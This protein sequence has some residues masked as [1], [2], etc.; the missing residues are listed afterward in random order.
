MKR[1][2]GIIFLIPCFLVAQKPT[3]NSISPRNLEVGDTITISGSNLGNASTRVFF[4]TSEATSVSGSANLLQAVVPAGVT[5]GHVT[6]LNTSNNLIGQS[7]ELFY[8][9]F[10][11][12]TSPT[13]GTESIVATGAQDAYD[14][15]LC[16]LNADNLNDVV[17]AHQDV[18][19][20]REVSYFIN[21]ST[22]STTNFGSAIAFD[23][24]SHE[25]GFVSVSCGDL[26]NDGTSEIVF[27][28]VNAENPF[29][30]YVYQGLSDTTPEA[31]LIIPQSGGVN[32]TPLVVK[33]SDIDNDG[34]KDIV[35]GVSSDD[36]D[37]VYIFRNQGSLTFSS[38][39]EI[40][41]SG[42]PNTGAFD[43][44]DLNNDL[45]PDIVILPFNVSN[46][47]IYVLRNNSLVNNFSFIEQAIISNSDQR[48]NLVL[49]DFNNDGLADIA[50]TS[51]RTVGSTS[52]DER[53]SIF[54]NTSDGQSD[55]SIT[56]SLVASLIIPSN[57]PW[58]L[59]AGDLNG[60]GLL[61][62]AIAC[63]GN[64]V[65]TLENTTTTNISFASA[66]LQDAASNTRNIAIGDLNGD[67]KPDI[68]YTNNVSLNTNGDLGVQMNTTC[69]DPTITPETFSFCTGDDFVLTATNSVNATYTWTIQSGTG[70][71]TPNTPNNNQATINLTS[72]SDATIRVQ[73]TQESC[74]VF[75]DYVV[76]FEPGS[77]TSTPTIQV[78]DTNGG[79]ICEGDQVTLSTST[80]FD[81]YLWMLPDGSTSSSSS[82]SL[83][84]ITAANA[85]EYSLIVRNTGNCS[86]VEVSQSITVDA[87]PIP[88]IFNNDDDVF[89]NDGLNDPTLEIQPITGMTYQWRRDG[90]DIT[91]SGTSLTVDQSGDYSIVIT[92]GNNCTQE[93]SPYTITAVSEPVSSINAV[94]E[95]CINVPTTFTATSTGQSGFTLEY[96][97]EVDGT[98]VS[99]TTPTELTTSFS[100]TGNHT[101]T[102]TTSYDATEVS[103]CS[104]QTVF[105][106]TVSPEPVVTFDQ[107]DGTQKCQAETL[108]IDVTTSNVSSYTWSVRNATNSPND[109]L[110]STGSSVV[111]SIDLST[112]ADVDSVYAIVEIV[113]NIGCQVKDSIKIRNFPSTIDISSPDFTTVLTDNNALLEEAIS[114]NLTAENSTN[115][116]WGPEA[117]ADRFSDVDATSTTFF[118]QNPTTVVTLT[119]TDNDGCLSATQITIQL[120]NLRPKKTFSPNGDGIND[121][122]E[123]LNIGDQGEANQCKV[124]I[125]DARGRN[126]LVTDTF[127]QG[128]CVWEG[129]SGGSQVTEGVYYF[130]MNCEGDD[131]LSKTGSILLAR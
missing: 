55:G 126:I 78:N 111:S 84:D 96:A 121:C 106:I 101:V 16:D 74:T 129:N 69:I 7:S 45:L 24:P 50:T 15:C 85:G 20:G 86:S 46:E 110:I 87:L 19:G 131:S 82:I 124:F 36:S 97:W 42:I 37:A 122:W 117:I 72:A 31:T 115:V 92:N 9:S 94:A 103:S 28:T 48:R 44:A 41:F 67:A 105:N 120:D 22:P 119:G 107:T 30:V 64:D 47:S 128:N 65:Y 90:A 1:L 108:L 25:D 63:V 56:F 109:T 73:I 57:L 59:E 91:G 27:T 34:L 6:V 26:N 88:I 125:F 127:D 32:Q 23:D 123:I 53:V 68:A 18:D 54:E 10:G 71:V 33:L 116:T 49:G 35:V 99:T 60:D 95:T 80:S 70:T 79:V 39:N 76:T 40:P 2:F 102:L 130:V 89:C 21:A 14:I 3:V 4:G 29:E 81:S 12:S 66:S 100:S 104:D 11:G 61:D 17:I 62:L 8:I 93:S 75:T 118:P 83:T 98:P 77:L 58:G 51:D 114:I 13:F 43:I 52:G 38:A 5:H 113:T 112:P